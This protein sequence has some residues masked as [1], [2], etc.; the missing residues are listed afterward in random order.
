[1]Y[2]RSPKFQVDYSFYL[3]KVL[4]TGACHGPACDHLPLLEQELSQFRV[5][6]IPGLILPPLAGDAIGYVD[7]IVCDILS[8]RP[9]GQ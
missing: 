5:A 9:H 4:K 3:Q 2:H 6:T 1:M 7:M 8:Q